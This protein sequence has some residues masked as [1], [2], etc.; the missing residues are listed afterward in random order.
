MPRVGVANADELVTIPTTM[1]G[2]RISTLSRPKLQEI[3]AALK[4]SLALG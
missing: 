3:D 4:F 1:L 2:E